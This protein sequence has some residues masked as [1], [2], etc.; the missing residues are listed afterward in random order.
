VGK[1]L[2]A[3]D[4]FIL[5]RRRC[6][7]LAELTGVAS[8]SIWQWGFIERTSTGLLLLKLGFDQV[9][10]FFSILDAWGR[11]DSP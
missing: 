10:Q 6:R 1:E 2:L 11:G 3:G 4:P 9:A 5:G 7:R 8:E